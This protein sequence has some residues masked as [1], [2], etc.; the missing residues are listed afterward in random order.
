MY[1]YKCSHCLRER[2]KESRV[3]GWP[4]C[5]Q[6]FEPMKEVFEGRKVRIEVKENDK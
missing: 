5:P 2:V 3:G 1:H 4:I 6:C